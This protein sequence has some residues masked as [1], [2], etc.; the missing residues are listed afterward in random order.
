MQRLWLIFAQAVT[1]AVAV[2]FVVSTFRPDWLPSRGA[3]PVPLP[4]PA[5]RGGPGAGASFNAAVQRALPS[6]VNIS[7]SMEMRTQ[8]HPLL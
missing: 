3:A 5:P 7:T 1:L 8:R 6:V 2:L 4:V